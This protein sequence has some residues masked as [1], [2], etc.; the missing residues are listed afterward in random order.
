MWQDKAVKNG[1]NIKYSCA[2]FMS[3]KE[4]ESCVQLFTSNKQVEVVSKPQIVFEGKASS[5]MKAERT[6]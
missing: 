4:E 1:L 2:A 6:R 5:E 3:E